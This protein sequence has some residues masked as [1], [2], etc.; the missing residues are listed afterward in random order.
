MATTADRRIALTFTGEIEYAQNFDAVQAITSPA[1]NE[2]VVLTTGANTIT[3][4]TG[5]VAVTI[6][7][8]AG[9]TVALTLKGVSGDTGIALALASPTSI[10]LATGV[11]NFVINAAS[12]VTVRFIYS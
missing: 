9:N 10:G 4:P 11:V 3:V 5:S 7:P 12:G 6:I 1:V 8:P 2:L